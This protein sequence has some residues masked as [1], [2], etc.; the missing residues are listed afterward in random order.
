[1]SKDRPAPAVAVVG[2]MMV[3]LIAYSDPLPAAGQTV[4]GSA[5]ELGYGGK[6]ANQAVTARRLGADVMFVGRV[7]DDVLG[8]LSLENLTAQGIDPVLVQQVDGRSTGVAPI[9]VEADGANRI[10]IV[11]GANEAITPEDVRD[12]LSTTARIDCVVCQLEI[13]LDAVSEALRIG[14]ATGAVT[15]L[16]PAPAHPDAA[17][18]F[19]AADWVV[20]NEHEFRLLWGATPSDEAILA[21]AAAWYCGLVVTLGEAGAAATQ[22]GREVVRRSP[23]PVTPIDTTGAGDAFVGGLAYALAAGDSLDAALTLGNVCGA[24]STQARGTQASFPPREAVD[25]LLLVEG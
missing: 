11:P 24:L 21:A 2:S 16:N 7:G 3:D 4:V 8:E 6:G 14:R 20:P 17:V 15:I 10:I 18:L 22:G 25:A 12:A 13:P 23:P 19:G 1:M 5:F 9:W